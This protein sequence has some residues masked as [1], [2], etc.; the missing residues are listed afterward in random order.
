MGEAHLASVS[1][2]A[3]QQRV[4]GYPVLAGW[5]KQQAGRPV[6]AEQVEVLCR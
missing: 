5:V 1:P 6:G 4:G 3:W 2:E